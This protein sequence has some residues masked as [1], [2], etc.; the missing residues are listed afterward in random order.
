MLLSVSPCG[1]FL[2]QALDLPGV[3]AH[4][5]PGDPFLAYS[6]C[7]VFASVVLLLEASG[8]L[9]ILQLSRHV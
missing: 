8:L 9:V 1:Y 6:F 7:E 4:S 5:L 3:F 2:P